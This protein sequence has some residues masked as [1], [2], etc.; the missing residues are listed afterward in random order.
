MGKK[1]ESDDCC[2][3]G[4]GSHDH[5]EEGEIKD[6]VCGMSVDSSKSQSY[7]HEGKKYQFCSRSCLEKFKAAPDKYLKIACLSEKRS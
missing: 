7:S 4:H 2:Y 6:P 1:H 3:S 5:V